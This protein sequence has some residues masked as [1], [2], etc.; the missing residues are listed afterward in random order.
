M[1]STPCG[2]SRVKDVATFKNWSC[3]V[4]RTG[5]RDGQRQA[6]LK[7]HRLFR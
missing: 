7:V 2:I 4:C 3:F 1:D 6:G 5:I